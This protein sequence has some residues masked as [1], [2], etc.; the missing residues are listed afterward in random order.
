MSVTISLKNDII[1]E[2]G[3]D[4]NE[5]FNKRVEKLI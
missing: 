4:V 5:P 3:G 1:E 2:I